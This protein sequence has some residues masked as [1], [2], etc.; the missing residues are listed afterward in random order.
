MYLCVR[1]CKE[2]VGCRWRYVVL[3]SPGRAPAEPARQGEDQDP[4]DEEE[5]APGEHPVSESH[6]RLRGLYRQ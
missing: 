2:V 5:G 3:W 1:D 4:A 6:W